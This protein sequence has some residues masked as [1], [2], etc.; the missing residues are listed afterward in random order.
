MLKPI[1]V[2]TWEIPKKVLAFRRV[3]P[4]SPELLQNCGSMLKS[5][6]FTDQA[7]SIS[8]SKF[9]ASRDQFSSWFWIE[10]AF[11]FSIAGWL[12]IGLVL[13]EENPLVIL[14]NKISFLF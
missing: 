13:G 6:S 7:C 10:K 2:L 5:V 3:G 4:R 1:C 9:T 8:G 14:I 12:I 11:S